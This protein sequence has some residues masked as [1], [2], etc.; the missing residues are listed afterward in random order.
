MSDNLNTPF[1]KSYNHYFGFE[2]R[3]AGQ[4]SEVTPQNR[5]FEVSQISTLPF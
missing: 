1:S 4:P 2:P 5:N 3:W